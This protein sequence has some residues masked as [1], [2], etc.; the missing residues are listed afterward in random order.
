MSSREGRI[1]MSKILGASGIFG[2]SYSNSNT[3][4]TAFREGQRSVG[5]IM[6]DWIKRADKQMYVKMLQEE[7]E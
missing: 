6:L 2:M 3:H 4:Q 7:E 1:V 5:R